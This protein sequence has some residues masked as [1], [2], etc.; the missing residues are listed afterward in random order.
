MNGNRQTALLCDHSGNATVFI[1]P[2][3]IVMQ[4]QLRNRPY[5]LDGLRFWSVLPVV[6]FHSTW[7]LFGCCQIAVQN[8]EGH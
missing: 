6:I 7:E 5:Y 2:R 4:S 3:M 8:G 1:K